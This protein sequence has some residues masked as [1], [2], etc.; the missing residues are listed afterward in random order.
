MPW[1]FHSV[2]SPRRGVAKFAMSPI[3]RC[4]IILPHQSFMKSTGPHSRHGVSLVETILVVVLISASATIGLTNFRRQP[5]AQRDAATMAEAIGMQ[6]RS[7]RMLA[8][9]EHTLAPPPTGD[10][11]S[12]VVAVR[13][14]PSDMSR[15]VVV[16]ER[17]SINRGMEVR[18]QTP[19]PPSMAVSVAPLGVR[20][21]G[22]GRVVSPN[23]NPAR[24]VNWQI[25]PANEPSRSHSVSVMPQT[26]AVRVRHP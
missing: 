10:F 12:V 16:T 15:R 24:R 25:A 17:W 3:G 14:D 23:L 8:I 20:F 26:S 22:F 5:V 19:I 1:F 6:I 9:R 4:R 11:H 21:D 13:P 2:V 7:A 18:Q